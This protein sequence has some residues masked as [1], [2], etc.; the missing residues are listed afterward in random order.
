MIGDDQVVRDAQ[1]AEVEKEMMI[2]AQAK[3]VGYNIRTGVRM[4]QGLNMGCFTVGPFR[5]S[6]SNAAHLASVIM[7][8]LDIVCHGSAS[9]YA[10]R[11]HFGAR[12]GYLPGWLIRGL[13]R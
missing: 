12:R 5:G 1:R 2:G 4:P 8:P 7:N 10:L 11:V 6:K 13:S 9:N 3:H